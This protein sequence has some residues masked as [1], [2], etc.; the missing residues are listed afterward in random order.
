MIYKTLHWLYYLGLYRAVPRAE[1]TEPPHPVIWTPHED[2]A[3][4]EGSNPPSAPT[5]PC[6]WRCGERGVGVRGE[7][8][9]GR[10]R[11]MSDGRGGGGPRGEVGRLGLLP[12]PLSEEEVK[13]READGAC[14]APPDG[15]GS[16]C[17]LRSDADEAKRVPPLATR[18]VTLG[19]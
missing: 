1:T 12:P 8:V 13:E 6:H 14:A 17:D 10:F 16:A 2:H 4:A 15:G 9:V 7:G 11:L 3:L 5:C 19:A 18:E